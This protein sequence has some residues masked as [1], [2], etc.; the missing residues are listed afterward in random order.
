MI[1]MCSVL[2]MIQKYVASDG[3]QTMVHYERPILYV[4]LYNHMELHMA[5]SLKMTTFIL[6][7]SK[8]QNINWGN[9]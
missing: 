2:S 8:R 6:L 7:E 1:Q 5:L 9:K 4:F 3:G